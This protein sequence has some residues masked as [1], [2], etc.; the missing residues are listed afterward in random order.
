MGR[1]WRGEPWEG[2]GDKMYIRLI[3]NVILLSFPRNRTT[4]PVDLL[5][6]NSERYMLFWTLHLQLQPQ[7][8]LIAITPIDPLAEPHSTE[9]SP[10]SPSGDDGQCLMD[11]AVASSDK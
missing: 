9:I 1:G 5:S 4:E 3:K 10:I 2:S 11:P 6:S 7:R 8:R